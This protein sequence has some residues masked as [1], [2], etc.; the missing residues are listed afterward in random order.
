M[1]PP[2]T[3]S[4]APFASLHP[5]RRQHFGLELTSEFTAAVFAPCLALAFGGAP[6]VAVLG[7]CVE[8]F[9]HSGGAAAA[10]PARAAGRQ[11]AEGRDVVKLDPK[12][13]PRPSPSAS[14]T[15]A[16]FAP[17]SSDAQAR[18]LLGA[19]GGASGGTPGRLGSIRAK[20]DLTLGG[21]P[22]AKFKPKVPQRRKAKA[23]KA[24][25][26]AAESAAEK[27][28][29]D[30]AEGRGGR[31]RGRGGG[32]G[33]SAF[34]RGRGRRPQP[35]SQTVFGA[36]SFVK[37]ARKSGPRAPGGSGS[38]PKSDS[39]ANERKAEQARLDAAPVDF[40]EDDFAK[41]DRGG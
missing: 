35:Q 4:M 5:R 13:Q 23:A 11:M 28:A 37:P 21:A 27:A 2:S 24:D 9:C 31:G 7:C 15:D 34:A 38:S 33:Q 40:G 3:A 26:A 12:S 32:R 36:G 41:R 17:I 8:G 39:V 14:P 10:A 19:A 25:G 6:S 18:A 1:Q 29:A 16:A 20:P 30:K 22:K